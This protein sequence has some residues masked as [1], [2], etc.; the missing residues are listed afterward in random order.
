MEFENQEIVIQLLHDDNYSSHCENRGFNLVG[1]KSNL[2][3]A[4]STVLPL[5]LIDL[6]VTSLTLDLGH[7]S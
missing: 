4:S 6:V 5:D 2:V 1:F 3:I 7:Q